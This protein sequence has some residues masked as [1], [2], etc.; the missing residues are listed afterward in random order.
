MTA[1]DI[2]ELFFHNFPSRQD[3]AMHSLKPP[4]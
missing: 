4:C 1:G 2:E 3:W